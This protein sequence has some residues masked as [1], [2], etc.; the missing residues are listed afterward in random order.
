MAA[1]SIVRKAGSWKGAANQRGI[2]IVGGV[3]RRRLMVTVTD[4]EH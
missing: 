2:A 1:E 4:R 3:T